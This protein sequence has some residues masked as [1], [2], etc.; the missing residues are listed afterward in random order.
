MKLSLGVFLLVLFRVAYS[1]P[2]ASYGDAYEEDYVSNGKA[3][4]ED[5]ANNGRASVEDILKMLQRTKLAQK[6]QNQDIIYE[7]DYGNNAYDETYPSNGEATIQDLL[8]QLQRTKLAR[9]QQDEFEYGGDYNTYDKSTTGNGGSEAIVQELFKQLQQAKLA[10]KQ[11]VDAY[12]ESNDVYSEENDVYSEEND[13]YAYGE[14]YYNGGNGMSSLQSELN[15]A[16]EGWWDTLT[17]LGKS[18]W[19]GAKNGCQYIG[20]TN[21]GTG[22]ST[23]GGGSRTGTGSRKVGGRRRGRRSQARSES[24]LTAG[25][26]MLKNACNYVNN[27]PATTEGWLGFSLQDVKNGAAKMLK[28]AKTG[29]DK[30]EA[31]PGMQK[32]LK[33][34]AGPKARYLD[35]ICKGLSGVGNAR[36]PAI[37]MILRTAV[38]AVE[39]QEAKS[40]NMKERL[41]RALVQSF[42]N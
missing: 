16:A 29:C 2:Q 17:T 13:V 9:K 40:A 23:T 28:M 27:A 31:Y 41:G 7:E 24:Y 33:L 39:Q 8:K 11:Q 19:N 37:Q 26:N 12:Q 22:G 30:Y 32:G 15:A 34:L 35:M 1:A 5:F 14:A 21:G 10:E 38:R 3:H 4:K 20:D 6:Q 42:A 25:W 18:A 36:K